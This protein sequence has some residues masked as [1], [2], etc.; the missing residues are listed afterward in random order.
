MRFLDFK[1]QSF[2]LQIFNQTALF[3]LN[4][5]NVILTINYGTE[6][7]YSWNFTILNVK[8]LI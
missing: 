5:K 8:A 2:L 3:L 7:L 6:V 4:S 1:K